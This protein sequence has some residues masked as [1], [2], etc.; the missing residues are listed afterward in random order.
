MNY[1]NDIILFE[2]I[3]QELFANNP[4]AKYNINKGFIENLNCPACKKQAKAYSFYDKPL[5]KSKLH[6][7][8][9]LVLSLLK[10]LS[11]Q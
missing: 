2:S 3:R 1:N 8:E 10:L 7:Y 6:F 5:A 9:L 11:G 4:N